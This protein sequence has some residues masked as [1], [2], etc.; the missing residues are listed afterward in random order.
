MVHSLHKMAAIQFTKTEKGKDKACYEGYYYNFE[1]KSRSDNEISFWVCEEYFKSNKCRGR[2][3]IKNGAFIKQTGVHNHSPNGQRKLALQADAR[4]KELATTTSQ[5]TDNIIS[6]ATSNLDEIVLSQMAPEAVTKRKIQQTRRASQ[7]FP[8]EPRNLE[9][10]VFPNNCKY[11]DDGTLFLL[12]DSGPGSGNNRICLFGTQVN[13]ELLSQSRSV[14]SDGTFGI[15]PTR[16]FYQL[17]T[18][19]GIVFGSIIPLIYALLP[20]K[21]TET[22]D[23]VFSALK[24]LQPSLNPQKWLTDFEKATMKSIERNFPQVRI[25]G[26]FFHLQQCLWRKVQEFG[27]T[28]AYRE[29]DGR[30]ARSARSLAALAFVPVPDVCSSFEI[31]VNDS[32]FDSRVQPIVDY[33]EDVWVGRLQTTGQRRQPTFLIPIW[34]MY[35]RTING[36]RRTNNDVEGWHRRF[37]SAIGCKNPSVFKCIDALKI[38]QKRHE[39]RIHRLNS[40]EQPNPRKRKYRDLN[41]RILDLVTK[42]EER[43]RVSYLRGI[44]HNFQ[45]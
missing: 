45:L 22:Y 34:N 24:C 5:T 10:L 6:V 29:E 30:F 12:Y 17:Y 13:L 18:I 43:E 38:E 25:T 32:Q 11:F 3:H 8:V 4:I 37:Q 33:F 16:L 40:G 2:I 41:D 7:K 31:L 44:A 23:R 42:Y 20:N 36:E 14:F 28:N 21:T 15:A 39:S 1:T 35:H 19:H 9:D 27:L 26:C